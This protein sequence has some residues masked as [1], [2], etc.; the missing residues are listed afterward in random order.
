[1][2]L[3]IKGLAA[4]DPYAAPLPHGTEVSTGVDRTSAGRVVPQGAVGRIV[5]TE[6]DDVDVT[7]VGVGTLRYSRRDVTPRK[8]G[9]LQFAA[10]RADAWESLHACVVLETTVGSRAWGL[11]DE[12]SDTDLRGA[13]AL[14]LPWT[15]GLVEA[16]ADLVSADGSATYWSVNKAVRNALRADPNTLEMLFV[17][18]ARACDPIGEWLLQERA[19]FVSAEI[20]GSFGRYALS[21]LKRLEQNARLADHRTHAL[22][23]L[24]DEPGL[25]LDEVALRLARI[26]PRAAPTEMDAVHQARQWIK[27]LYRSLYDQGLLATSEFAAMARLAKE[28]DAALELP[29]ELRPKNAYN[30]LR[31]IRTAADWLRTGEPR[32]EVEGAFRDRLVDIKKGRVA[33]DEVLAE[34]EAMAPDLESARSQTPLPPRPDVARA[35]TLLKRVGVELARR[36]VER[37][38]GPLGRDAPDAPEATWER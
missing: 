33:L 10:R 38:P 27:Q 31:L 6:G 14:P 9:Q 20:Y 30:L 2:D 15:L 32:F 11:A 21:Q 16:P 1:M 36:W 34:A 7:I 29:R 23:W 25:S 12:G 17:P 4:L 13:F 8:A 26:S 18:G 22:A 37:V 28:S 3:R 35:D 24:R 5:R 19:A